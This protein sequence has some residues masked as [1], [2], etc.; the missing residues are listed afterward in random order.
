MDVIGRSAVNNE[1]ETHVVE[2]WP[3]PSKDVLDH[4]VPQVT[5]CVSNSAAVALESAF[6]SVGWPARALTLK[7]R[8]DR[9]YLTAR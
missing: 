3:K 1:V 4:E 2:F 7:S 6:H 9:V 5:S 8:V